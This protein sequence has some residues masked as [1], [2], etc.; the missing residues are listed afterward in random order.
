MSKLYYVA[1]FHLEENEKG[2]WVEFPDLPGCFTNGNDLYSAME[3]AKE[4]LGYQSE[5]NNERNIISP[6]S[7]H[8]IMKQYPNE[9][10]QLVEY[11]AKKF[12]RKYK[13]KAIKKTLTIPEWLNDE[14][15]NQGINFSKV[16]QEALITKLKL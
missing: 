5:E 8:E 10:V 6:T 9:L 12:A 16:L 1:V 4:A 15:V 7:V 3:H 11:D 13:T 2:F 14:A